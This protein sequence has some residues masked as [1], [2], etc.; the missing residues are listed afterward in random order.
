MVTAQTM[1]ETDRLVALIIMAA[2][3]G[4]S[5]DRLLMLLNSKLA[6]WRFAS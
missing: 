2:F 5:I 4:F 1:M 6:P 3:I